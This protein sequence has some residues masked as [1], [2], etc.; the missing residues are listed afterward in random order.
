MFR[1]KTLLVCAIVAS[2]LLFGSLLTPVLLTAE[3]ITALEI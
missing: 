2:L 1:L 3:L